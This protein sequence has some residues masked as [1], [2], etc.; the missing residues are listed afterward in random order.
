VRFLLSLM[1][2]PSSDNSLNRCLKIGDH[3]KGR[4]GEIGLEFMLPFYHLHDSA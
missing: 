4:A 3:Y 2:S 1:L